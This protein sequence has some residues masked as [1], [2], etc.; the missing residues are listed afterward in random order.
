[1]NKNDFMEKVFDIISNADFHDMR[2]DWDSGRKE[3]VFKD[4]NGKKCTIRFKRALFGAVSYISLIDSDYIEVLYYKI[5]KEEFRQL[6]N[7][8][9]DREN[10]IRGE[11]LNGIFKSESRA[12]KIDQVI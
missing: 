11:K 4:D 9:N 7:A 8:I 10:L 3:V 6:I 12:N 5:S 1:M 2:N